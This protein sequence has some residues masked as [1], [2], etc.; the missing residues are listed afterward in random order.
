MNQSKKVSIIIPVYNGEKYI[1][2]CYKSIKNQTYKNLEIIFINDCSTDKTGTILEEIKKE[3]PRCKIINN[4]KNSGVSATRN[5]G[6][7]H[8]TGKYIAFCDI[9]DTMSEIMIEKMLKEIEKESA[10]ICCCG[11]KRIDS[12]GKAK[13]VLWNSKKETYS[14]KEAYKNW[15][16]G[17]KIGNSMY[18][19]L[20]LRE[21]FEDVE[22]PVGEIFEESYVIT[23]LFNK[24]NK[25]VHCGEILYNY[26]INNNSII[27]S[28]FND[29]KLIVYER[30]KFI[31]SFLEDNNYNLAKEVEAFCIRQNM[32][33]YMGA[34]KN[35]KN[36]NPNTYKKVKQQFKKMAFK[37]IINKNISLSNKI[38]IIELYIGIFKLRKSI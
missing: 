26:Y 37:G 8:A 6:I 21:L 13:E 11:L 24:C 27:N 34:I 3:D 33:L 15:L 30:E 28:G 38:H 23:K 14:A 36:M 29:N 22:F 5:N 19:K 9:D 18:T 4:K 7:K 31:K 10:E 2:R 16:I 1:E 35:K 32:Y 20:V 17:K 25:I 12:N